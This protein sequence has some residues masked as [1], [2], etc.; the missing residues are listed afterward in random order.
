MDV[1]LSSQDA[2]WDACLRELPGGHL[3]QSATWGAFKVAFGWRCR[4]LVV[5]DAGRIVA[6]AQSLFRPVPMGCIGYVPKGPVFDPQRPDY[7]DVLLPA[8]HDLARQAGAIFLKVEPPFGDDPAGQDLWTARG[9]TAH[10]ATVQPRTTIVLD[11][12]PDPGVILGRMKQKWRYNIR[13]AARKGVT[14]RP[15]TAA[16][17]PDFYWLMQATG[18]RDGFAVHTA[19]YYAEAWRRLVGAGL[20]E[21]LLAE[22]Q[23]EL[24]AGLFVTAFGRTATYM[25]GASS[26]LHRN[27]MPNH[28]L[29]W[30]AIQWARQRGCVEYDLWGIPDEVASCQFQVP[31]L[32]CGSD[33][34]PETFNLQPS[35]DGLWGVY[36]FKQGFGG[37]VVRWPGAYDYVY[38]PGLYWLGTRVLPRL[39]GRLAL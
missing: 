18:Q 7:L 35:T 12:A 5:A 6:G 1:L 27:L 31:G 20:A 21:L 14:V 10:V 16:D 37:Q 9:F 29:Q 3:L 4:R 28:L 32:E 19:A 24:L 11:I 30:A 26:D 23:G 22:Y 34:Q 2:A 17:L 8:L 38:R 13:L 36:R 25:Y 39:R 15:A 33:E